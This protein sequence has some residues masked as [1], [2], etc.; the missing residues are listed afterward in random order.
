MRFGVKEILLPTYNFISHRAR[1][2]FLNLLDIYLK[3][4]YKK[5]NW[6]TARIVTLN[7]K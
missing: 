3:C 1:I 2:E 6:D 5:K 4:I 7:M